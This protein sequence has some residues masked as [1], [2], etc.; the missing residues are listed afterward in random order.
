M[1]TEILTAAVRKLYDP[2]LWYLQDVEVDLDKKLP[3]GRGSFRI[4]KS[5]FHEEISE[6]T[7]AQVPLCISQLS[8]VFLGH[9][10]IEGD[11]LDLDLSLEEYLPW[12]N[13]HEKLGICGLEVHFTK[14][15]RY[16][17]FKGQISITRTKIT[18]KNTLFFRHLI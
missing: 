16:R 5:E 18:E 8:Y 10:M 14:H 1:G 7:L 12:M 11:F 3:I 9:S 13:E 15:L 6:I 4:G 17:E 2:E